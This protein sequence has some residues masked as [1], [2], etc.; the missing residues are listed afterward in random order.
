M[1]RTR[2]N[3][4]FAFVKLLI[5]IVI[6]I[7]FVMLLR[8]CILQE[9]GAG[10]PITMTV[11]PPNTVLAP[12][13]P[14]TFEV[15]VALG[16]PLPTIVKTIEV[17]IDENDTFRDDRLVKN[18]AVKY[19][20]FNPARPY[21]YATFTLSC[22][23]LDPVTGKFDLEGPDDVSSS[24]V[25]HLVHA[26][27]LRLRGMKSENAIVRC[28]IPVIPIADASA[29]EGA[30]Y[31]VYKVV[32]ATTGG[33]EIMNSRVCVQCESPNEGCP[34]RATLRLPEGTLEVT[35]EG[36]KCQACPQGARVFERRR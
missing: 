24:E 12:G 36:P 23:N 13:V 11:T 3:A 34:S 30:S 21:A 26:E 1:W 22:K 33:A 28:A 20:P 15:Q 14:A 17:R 32:E 35:S 31:C 5:L 9:A 25:T 29:T 10:E 2:A 4:G 6:V 8:A 16:H 18:L 7:L 27:E 19:D